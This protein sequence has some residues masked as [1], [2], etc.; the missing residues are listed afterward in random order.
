MNSDKRLDAR[1]SAKYISGF[2][3]ASVGFTEKTTAN[4]IG[5]LVQQASS[6]RL[7][8]SDILAIGAASLKLPPERVTAGTGQLVDAIIKA[9]TQKKPQAAARS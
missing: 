7:N 8:T 9:G 2:Q 5:K 4:S 3:D 1:T 6:A